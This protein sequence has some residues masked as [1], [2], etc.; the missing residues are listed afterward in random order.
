MRILITG[1]AGFIGVNFTNYWLA[2]HATDEIIGVDCL[3]YAANQNALSELKKDNRFVFYQ[4]DVCERKQI[5]NIF[6]K[7][8]PDIVVHFAAE[9]HV[10]RSIVSPDIFMRTNV[11]GTQVVLDASLHFNVKRFHQISTDEVYGDLPIDSKESFTENSPLKPSSPYSASKAAAD[12]LVLACYRTH[13][14]PITISRSSNNYGKYQHVEKFIPTIIKK[15]IAGMR[16]P[17]YGD[18]K[19]VRDWLFVEDHC[20]AIEKILQT[21]KV[22]EVYNIG[23]D[24]E[25]SNLELVFEILRLLK[26]DNN[27]IEF[28]EDRKGHD[29][30]YSLNSYK[31]R[32]ELGWKATTPFK[33]GLLKTIDCY[34]SENV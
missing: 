12:L 8:R 33:C 2:K 28:I 17:V 14:L 18:G 19:N 6:E 4:T 3:T 29:R 25:K 1:C 21:G 7:E 32:S 27:R 11:I 15:A 26:K 13:G 16:I 34:L 20:T 9:S 23:G 31:I 10:D 22:G 5:F 30:K 24:N